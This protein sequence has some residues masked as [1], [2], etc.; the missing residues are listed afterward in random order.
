[1]TWLEVIELYAI[2][3]RNRGGLDDPD[4]ITSVAAALSAPGAS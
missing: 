2:N 3:T 1:M 4:S